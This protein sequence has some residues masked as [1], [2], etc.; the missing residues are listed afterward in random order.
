M[1]APRAL[2]SAAVE[3]EEITIAHREYDE[4]TLV[5]IDFGGAEVA[6]DVIDDRAIVVAGDQ[7]FE[8]DVPAEATEVTA[9]GG[10]VRIET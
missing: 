5:A 9:N 4:E 7:Q 1:E 10:I 2:R 3:Q 6:L 8:F